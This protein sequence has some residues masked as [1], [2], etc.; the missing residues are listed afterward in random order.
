M[1]APESASVHQ[2]RSRAPAPGPRAASSL[3]SD[4][5]VPG[6]GRRL[7]HRPGRLARHLRK[8][9]R[10]IRASIRDWR[11]NGHPGWRRKPPRALILQTLYQQRIYRLLARR[12]GVARKVMNRLDGWW[13]WVARSNVAA[14]AKLRSLVT[15]LEPPLHVRTGRAAPAGR[16]LEL[17]KRARKRFGV[18]AYVL[19][20]VNFVETKFNRVRSSS[21]AG[22]QGPMQFLPSTWRQYGLGGDIHNDRDAIMGAANYLHASGAPG[23]LRRALYAYNNSRRY[24]DAVMLYATQMRANIRNYFAYYNWQV[25]VIT[26][27]GDVRLTGPR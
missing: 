2:P 15:P 5:F 21:S 23:H 12:E 14:G 16:L 19:A 17:Y 24:V 27:K 9:T 3:S 7:P 8:T 26:T 20:A 6:P 10:A 11:T 18:P 4:S 13:R 22:A 25:F 1:G